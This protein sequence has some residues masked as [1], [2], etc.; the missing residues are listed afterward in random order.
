MF[1][2]AAITPRGGVFLC[3][4]RCCCR[5]CCFSLFLIFYKLLGLPSASRILSAW[6]PVIVSTLVG[7]SVLL[8]LE[9]DNFFFLRVFCNNLFVTVKF[10][11]CAVFDVSE[12]FKQTLLWVLFNSLK[13]VKS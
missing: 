8:S 1:A 4:D 12:V 5:V 2:N 7:I 13:I 10:S 11:A 3:P 6:S 9:D